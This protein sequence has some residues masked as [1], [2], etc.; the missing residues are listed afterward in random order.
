MMDV[1]AA[2]EAALAAEEA[3]LA[4]EEAAKCHCGHKGGLN[5][6]FCGGC[7]T[8]NICCGAQRSKANKFCPMCGTLYVPRS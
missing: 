1:L 8:K 6:K 3:A 4:A 5:T 7:G 2:E